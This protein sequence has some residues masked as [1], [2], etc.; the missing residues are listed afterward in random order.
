M[1]YFS[2]NDLWLQGYMNADWVG[3]VDAWKSTSNYIFL[4][5]R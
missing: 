1:T 4:A 2:F 5:W 3:D